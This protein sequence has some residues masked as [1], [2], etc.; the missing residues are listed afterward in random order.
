[1][2]CCL[3]SLTPGDRRIQVPKRHIPENTRA[4]SR[5]PLGV[6]TA[7]KL[8]V[9]MCSQDAAEFDL[10]ESPAKSQQMAGVPPGWPWQAH[11]RLSSGPRGFAPFRIYLSLCCSPHSSLGI[12]GGRG[13]VPHIPVTADVPMGVGF[14]PI[15]GARGP[16]DNLICP[17]VPCQGTWLPRE[18]A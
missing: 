2:G 11:L 18:V 4:G 1:M 3:R 9:A 7:F 13:A 5:F 16:A 12:R 15:R 10:G 8:P 6:P 17:G 14:I